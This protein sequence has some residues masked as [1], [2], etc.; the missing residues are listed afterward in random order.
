MCCGSYTLPALSSQA[1]QATHSTHL[2]PLEMNG[3][4]ERTLPFPNQ[5]RKEKDAGITHHQALSGLS[6]SRN[7]HWLRHRRLH[8]DQL[9]K[10]KYENLKNK[11]KEEFGTMESQI[12]L[13]AEIGI[14]YLDG[15]LTSVPRPSD[16][17]NLSQPTQ[18]HSSISTARLFTIEIF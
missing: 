2:G 8:I 15:H 13:A 3:P 9:S 1:Q 6:R 4:P 5:G 18:R 16:S 7:Q 17:R 14:T 12:F 11:F 10:V